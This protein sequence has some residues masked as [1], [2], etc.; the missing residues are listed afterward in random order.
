MAS[1]SNGNMVSLDELAPF[2]LL[3]HPSNPNCAYPVSEGY[4][5]K[6]FDE[7]LLFLKS[8]LV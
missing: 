7:P 2:Y 8:K 3:M 4:C 6:I 1:T 5:F